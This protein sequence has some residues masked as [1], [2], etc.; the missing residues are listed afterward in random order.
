[1][2]NMNNLVF[3]YESS[4]HSSLTKKVVGVIS[5]SIEAELPYPFQN[6]TRAPVGTI[7]HCLQKKTVPL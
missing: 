3:H 4:E 5:S 7:L 1:M 2:E 6:Q